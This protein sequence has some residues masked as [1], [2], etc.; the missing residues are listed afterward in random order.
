MRKICWFLFLILL[1][2][3]ACRK[4]KDNSAKLAEVNNE[5]LTLEAFQ[6]T[7]G[8]EEWDSL[9]AD[10]RKRFVEDWVNLTLLA[11]TADKQ[12]MSKDLAIQ[13]KI[14][15]AAKKVKANALIARRLAEV[16]VS[17]D[18]L[19]S[20]FR[21]HQAEFQKPSVQYQIQ[22]IQ[23]PDKLSAERL[24][25]QLNQGLDFDAAVSRYSTEPLKDK[26]GMLGFV[27]AASADSSFWYKARE[28]QKD[29]PG[30]VLK[31]QLWYVFRYTDMKEME[32]EANFEDF[33]AEIKRK[34][35][36]EKQEEV[37]QSLLREI[38]SQNHEIYYY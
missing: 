35:I 6:S 18:Q 12:G 27:S 7:F 16:Q 17:E 24:L 38:K 4:D 30:V 2:A 25:M 5:V 21:I 32:G 33:R 22:R 8:V 9:P 36:L 31:D 37:F 20:Y 23:L 26:K 28:M 29:E 14:S 3:T 34:I 13:Q 1:L 11:Q 15:Y 19:F 10:A